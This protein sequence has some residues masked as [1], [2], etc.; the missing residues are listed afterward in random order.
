MKS[1]MDYRK[2]YVRPDGQFMVNI[3]KHFEEIGVKPGDRIL[4]YVEDG[5]VVIEK[6]E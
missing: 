6:G 5:K 2:P 3:K 4:I 1:L